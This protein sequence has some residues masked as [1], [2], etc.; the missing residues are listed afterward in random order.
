VTFRPAKSSE[1]REPVSFNPV[2]NGCELSLEIEVGRGETDR[3]LSWPD[4]RRA[5]QNDGTERIAAGKGAE[6]GIEAAGESLGGARRQTRDRLLNT[7]ADQV[8][9]GVG[10]GLAAE[11][12]GED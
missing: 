4:R 12:I 1:E 7:D 10:A 5:P 8:A 11:G 2:P 3:E 6:L 9:C